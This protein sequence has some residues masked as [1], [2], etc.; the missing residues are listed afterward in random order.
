MILSTKNARA[1][2]AARRAKTKI[3]GMSVNRAYIAGRDAARDGVSLECNPFARFAEL[4]L[5]FAWRDGFLHGNPPR[6][7]EPAK[8]GL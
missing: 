4:E 1:L 5:H 3:T 8:H 6:Y 7:T 2:S